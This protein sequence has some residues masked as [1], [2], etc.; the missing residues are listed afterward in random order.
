VTS[1]VGRPAARAAFS[2][3]TVAQVPPSWE[4]A[5]TE[6]SC[7]GSSDSSNASRGVA[8]VPASDRIAAIAIEACSLVP[9]PVTVTGPGPRS[10]SATSVV[11][12]VCA[13]RSSTSGS[14]LIISCITHGGASRSS[15]HPSLSHSG[16]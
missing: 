12:T 9:Q 3:S 6:P 15:G 4:T 7:G 14:L 5:I 13:I 1:A 8:G 16:R 10:S 2:A 11:S